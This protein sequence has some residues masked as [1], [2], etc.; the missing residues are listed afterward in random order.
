M[1]RLGGVLRSCHPEPVAAV[2]LLATLLAWEAGRGGY[3]VVIGLAVLCGQLAV[4]WDNDAI[5]AE[6]DRAHRRRDKPVVSGEVSVALLRRL[7]A[8]AL[9]ACVVL[10]LATGIVSG[11]AHL[12]AVAA[13]FGYNRR[14]KP[15][16]LSVAPYALAFALMPAV[17]TLGPPVTHWPAWWS[18][19]AGAAAGAGAHFTQALPDIAGDRVSGVRGLPQRLGEVPSAAAAAVLLGLAAL[20][21]ALGAPSTPSRVALGVSLLAGAG[22]M[23]TAIAGRRRP[24][25]QLSIAGALAVVVALAAS[26]GR[27]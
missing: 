8:V 25:F 14:L 4:G 7:E 17:A 18:L 21:V 6:L 11:L 3:A 19:A 10:S 5:D 1:R 16:A 9:V 24:A 2:T 27:F 15:T 13:A 23:G 22:M 20:A 26:G 12:V